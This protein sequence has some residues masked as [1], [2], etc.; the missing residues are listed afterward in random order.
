MAF[1]KVLSGDLKDE[2]GAK[3]GYLKLAKQLKAKGLLG[4]A[5]TVKSIAKDEG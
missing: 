2:A 5:R 1:E 4:D 3:K